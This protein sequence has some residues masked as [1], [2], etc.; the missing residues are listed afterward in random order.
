MS[1]VFLEDPRHRML[2]Q[3]CDIQKPQSQGWWC[4]MESARIDGLYLSAKH[5]KHTLRYRQGRS[6][7]LPPPGS[8]VKIESQTSW[9]LCRSTLL[10]K[11]AAASRWSSC[12]FPVPF[13]IP[14][15]A[16]RKTRSIFEM[17]TV[18]LCVR[19]GKGKGRR[20]MQRGHH[21]SEARRMLSYELRRHSSE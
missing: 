6:A 13:S 15:R 17:N 1:F 18:I 11:E 10:A 3:D 12:V 2:H 4:L 21:C 14:A 9:R 7:S 5:E 20:V 8:A 16:S 19:E